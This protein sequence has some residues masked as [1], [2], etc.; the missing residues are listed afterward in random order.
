MDIDHGYRRQYIGLDKP[1][2]GDDDPELGT[3]GHHVGWLVRDQQAQFLSRLL[4]GARANFNAT[5]SP[6]VRAGN[7]E[8]DVVACRDQCPKGAGRHLGGAEK[9]EPH[10]SEGA[11]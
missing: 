8:A 7:H 5:T 11:R 3:G 4:D 2:V 1:P 9:G 10:N 6:R